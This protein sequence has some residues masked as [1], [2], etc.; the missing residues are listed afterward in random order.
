METSQVETHQVFHPAN[1]SL[2]LN[3]VFGV[4]LVLQG[5]LVGVSLFK[6]I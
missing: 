2:L 6:N 1:F 4:I 5:I 3:F